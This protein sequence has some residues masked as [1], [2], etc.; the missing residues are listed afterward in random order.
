MCWMMR[1]VASP[2][3]PPAA[4]CCRRRAAAPRPPGSN[5]HVSTTGVQ[6]PFPE[7]GS[8]PRKNGFG[9][10]GLGVRPEKPR[11]HLSH[12]P[13]HDVGREV[14]GQ[15]TENGALPRGIPA[16]HLPVGSAADPPRGRGAAHLSV[17]GGATVAAGNRAVGGEALG[18]G[19]PP[20]CDGGIPA[21]D[22]SIG[23]VTGS[24]G[25]LGAAQLPVGGDAAIATRHQTIGTAARG[26]RGWPGRL[27]T[28]PA[29]WVL[30]PRRRRTEHKGQDAAQPQ[31]KAR[32]RPR[33]PAASHPMAKGGPAKPN[34]QEHSQ[35]PHAP[36]TRRFVPYSPRLDPAAQRS[37]P[38][39]RA[40]LRRFAALRTAP[41]TARR[42]PRCGPQRRP[43]GRRHRAR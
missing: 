28:G 41:S 39:Q 10:S 32:R 21:N 27:G 15:A 35:L 20:T 25:R 16:D 37:G 11:P 6:P 9:S 40:G 30:R 38:V 22:L 42:S 12:E 24:P 13:K 31:P 18:R 3:S 4:E 26:G 2:A 14:P 1:C 19:R 43:A 29:A 34:L 36:Q 7:P 33:R 23:G 5:P 17:G 8:R